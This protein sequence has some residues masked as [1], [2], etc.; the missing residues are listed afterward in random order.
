MTDLGILVTGVVAAQ[1][2]EGGSPT[3]RRLFLPRISVRD[4][5]NQV[6]QCQ[7]NG[8]VLKT[9]CIFHWF[10]KRTLAMQKVLWRPGRN[11]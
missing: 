11:C 4:L 6:R 1:N 7:I 3:R 9:P 5:D 10:W 2:F 8:R